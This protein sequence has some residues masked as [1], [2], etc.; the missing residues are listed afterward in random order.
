MCSSFIHSESNKGKGVNWS[1][2]PE[3]IG[4]GVQSPGSPLAKWES[5]FNEEQ[6]STHSSLPPGDE[7]E[8]QLTH[9]QLWSRELIQ[10]EDERPGSSQVTTKS[11]ASSLT[12]GLETLVIRATLHCPILVSLVTQGLGLHTLGVD[13]VQQLQPSFYNSP[14]NKLG[15]FLKL[16]FMGTFIIAIVP[17]RNK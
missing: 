5:K 4:A 2:H 6:H 7:G 13:H 8:A 3:L 12:S 10:S 17:C 9:L 1:D 15:N 16:W 14:V 11:V